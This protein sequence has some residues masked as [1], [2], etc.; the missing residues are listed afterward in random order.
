MIDYVWEYE[1]QLSKESGLSPY[2]NQHGNPSEVQ[3]DEYVHR[4]YGHLDWKRKGY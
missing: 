3:Y 2:R 4:K 1:K